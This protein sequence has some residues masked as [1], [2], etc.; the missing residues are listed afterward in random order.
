VTGYL[1]RLV[2]MAAQGKVGV[3]PIVRPWRIEAGVQERARREF[4]PEAEAHPGQNPAPA[5]GV[6]SGEGTAATV[7]TPFVDGAAP[8]HDQPRPTA[9]HASNR[10]ADEKDPVTETMTPLFGPIPGGDLAAGVTAAGTGGIARPPVPRRSQPAP[11]ADRPGGP[12]RERHTPVD[13]ARSDPW[14]VTARPGPAVLPAFRREPDR[15][16]EPATSGGAGEADCGDVEI[17]I[18][19][20]EVTAVSPAPA[21]PVAKAARKSVN[22]SE[23]LRNGR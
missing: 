23:Y 20:I 18:G 5:E 10:V 6:A 3:H 14:P 1:Q 15:W 17:H 8:G 16:A 12:T 2:T 13:P 9:G 22:L 19:R 7:A 4:A 21:A 11:P